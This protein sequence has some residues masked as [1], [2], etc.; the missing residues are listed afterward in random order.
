MRRRLPRGRLELPSQLVQQVAFG[1]GEDGNG[2]RAPV[3]G[4]L[5]QKPSHPVSAR[6][7]PDGH[8]QNG[9]LVGREQCTVDGPV[10]TGVVPFAAQLVPVQEQPL[11][12]L[13]RRGSLRH[14]LGLVTPERNDY[15]PRRRRRGNHGF[16][17]TVV[18]C[19][20]V[21]LGQQFHSAVSVCA[22]PRRVL[23]NC[24]GSVLV[25]GR[26]QA[27]AALRTVIPGGS[28]NPTMALTSAVMVFLPL[29]PGP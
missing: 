26:A 16:V 13:G 24:G 18:G 2:R 21:P 10:V 20:T 4:R 28:V 7:G 15:V 3:V 9:R 14:D 1:E 8:G 25:Y 6:P 11:E 19:V 29:V 5:A 22:A 12:P 23:A 27:G 17:W